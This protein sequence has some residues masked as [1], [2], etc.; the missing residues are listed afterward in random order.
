M[1][2]ILRQHKLKERH[3][4]EQLQESK[5]VIAGRC[6]KSGTCRL[7][8]TVFDGVKENKAKSNAVEAA[9]SNKEREERI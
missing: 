2:K 8:M 7:G 3:P 6:F 1:K 4:K 9:R 5:K